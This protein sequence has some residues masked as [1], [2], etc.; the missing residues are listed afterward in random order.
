MAAHS[1]LTQGDDDVTPASNG[2]LDRD[3][4]RRAKAFDVL[5]V[6]IDAVTRSEAVDMV[7]S[8]CRKPTEPRYVTV[9]GMHGIME[10]H[11]SAEIMA[12]H[13]GADLTIPDGMSIVY[14]GR[15]ARGMQGMERVT[16]PDFMAA[17]LERDGGSLRHFLYGGAPGL[18]EQLAEVMRNRY[19]AQVTGLYVPPFRPLNREEEAELERAVTAAR[20]DIVWVGLSTPKQELFMARYHEKLRPPV[21]VGVGAAFDFLA[22]TKSRAPTWMGDAGFE[23]LY[24][25]ASEPRRL[26]RRVLIQAPRFCIR[27]IAD[28]RERRGRSR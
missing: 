12:A 19:G 23:W 16:G 25:F 15:Y 8:W 20:P 13:A 9:T 1:D 28:A 7:L 6:S 14:V 4:V 2:T 5:G 17:L 26:W 10:S 18:A 24:R 22:G 11:D 21:M 27:L 3:V